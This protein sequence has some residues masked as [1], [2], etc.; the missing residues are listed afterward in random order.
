MRF[1]F[2]FVLLFACTCSFAQKNDSIM[3]AQYEAALTKL[4][5]QD[6]STAS[7]QFTQLINSGFANKEVYAKRG[8]AWY[9]LKEYEKAKADLDEAVKGRINSVELFES[10]GNTKYN[11]QDYQGAVNDLE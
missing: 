1:L 6:Y 7:L 3:Q 9:N 10:R 4:K 11:L 2:S 8:V 5:N